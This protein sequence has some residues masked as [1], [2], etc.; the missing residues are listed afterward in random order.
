MNER[1]RKKDEMNKENTVH[2]SKLQEFCFV[3]RNHSLCVIIED[4]TTAAKHLYFSRQAAGYSIVD[5]TV[6][7]CWQNTQVVSSHVLL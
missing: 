1:D 4:L 6:Y 3:I 7:R 5:F 2:C